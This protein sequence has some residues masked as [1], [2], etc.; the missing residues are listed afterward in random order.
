MKTLIG[1]A[2]HARVARPGYVC[3]CGRN[4]CRRT[5]PRAAG[6]HRSD[7]RHCE[8]PHRA[9]HCRRAADREFIV[10][11][12]RLVAAPNRTPPVMAIEIPTFEFAVSEPLVIRL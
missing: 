2:W 8:A 5:G 10:T 11:A 1:F 4:E 7:H 9:A 6:G 3:L 12:K